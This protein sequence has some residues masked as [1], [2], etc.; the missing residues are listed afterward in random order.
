[1]V[2]KKEPDEL[3]D[4]VKRLDALLSILLSLP[5]GDNKQ[6]T[7]LKRAELLSTAGVE[8]NGQQQPLLRNVEMARILG[9]S[10]DHLGLLMHKLR[11]KAKQ[12]KKSR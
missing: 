12:R 7:L 5:N 11:K 10:Q 1:M 6:L 2:T 4:I 8:K 3:A 9:I